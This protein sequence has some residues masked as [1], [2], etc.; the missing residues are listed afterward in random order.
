MS[1]QQ[2]YEVIWQELPLAESQFQDRVPLI[3]LFT[4]VPDDPEIP[5]APLIWRDAK[6]KVRQFYLDRA[7]SIRSVTED[8][9]NG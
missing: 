6:K 7:A 9:I 1:K 2:L 3:V 5:Y 4:G 8:S